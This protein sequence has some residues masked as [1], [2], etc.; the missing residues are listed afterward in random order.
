MLCSSSAR[1]FES[2]FTASRRVSIAR[3]N[4]R[5]T[6]RLATLRSTQKVAK[7]P[8]R[9]RITR[10]GGRIAASR[11]TP[12]QRTGTRPQ[13]SAGQHQSETIQSEGAEGGSMKKPNDISV[14]CYIKTA[15]QDS[16]RALELVDAVLCPSCALESASPV[17]LQL[18]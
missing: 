15:N 4:A 17:T 9:E 1:P 18:Q 6:V 10:P 3:A 7:I 14:A 11:M 16:R 13:S 8:E 2:H 5:L 12:K